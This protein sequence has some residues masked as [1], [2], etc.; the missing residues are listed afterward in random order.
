VFSGGSLRTRRHP[1]LLWTGLLGMPRRVYSYD[2]G[3]GWDTPNLVSSVFSFV[4]AFGIA[5]LLL[6]ASLA[7]WTTYL[8][9][10][11]Y[12]DNKNRRIKDGT[13][14][15]HASKALLQRANKAL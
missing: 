8:M 9:V 7:M 15:M 6:F 14:C 1:A 13:W 10:I 12:L 3:L 4:M 11:L 5:T 2:A